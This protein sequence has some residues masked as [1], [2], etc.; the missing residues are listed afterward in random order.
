MPA[1]PTKNKPP[2]TVPPIKIVQQSN[3]YTINNDST[4]SNSEWQQQKSS[5]RS[6]PNSPVTPDNNQGKKT[7][8]FFSPNRFSALSVDEPS[9]DPD[10]ADNNDVYNQNESEHITTQTI[11]RDLPPPIYVKG[12]INFAELR[13]AI[14]KIIGPD[15][16]I[17]KSTTTQIKIQTNTPD[18][19]RTLIHFLKVEK[20]EYHTF[21]LQSEKSFRAVI[22]NIHHTTDPTDIASAL[23]EIGFTVRQVT[24]IKHQKTKI[25]LPLFFVDLAPE[26]ISKEIFKITSLLNTKIKVE[27]PHKRR[28]IPQCQNCQTYGHTKSYCSHS[29]RCVKCGGTHPTTTCT[30]SPDLPAKCAL[31]DGEHPANYKGCAVYKELQQR[32]HLPY[33]SRHNNQHH[34]PQSTNQTMKPNYQP[35]P[36]PSTQ[37]PS[38]RTNKSYAEA[39]ANTSNA[40]PPT[41]SSNT[42]PITSHDN[43]DITKFLEEFK[44]LINP[45]ISLITALMSKLLNDT[46][47]K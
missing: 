11:K 29:P 8:L 44:C 25:P 46:H 40:P 2:K 20:A 23:E 26:S 43:N 10:I 5:K 24:N 34:Q 41:P 13:N 37:N 45:L 31:C 33:N 22:K 15:S 30:K 17:C 6:L 21:Q 27:E 9:N 3:T 36:Q 14:T 4:L 12:T 42:R 35:N 18:N 1:N 47:N 39:T 28:E 38:T 32:R 16:F 7:K 19:Y